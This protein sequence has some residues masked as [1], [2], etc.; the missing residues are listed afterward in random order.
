MEVI[1]CFRKMTLV[2]G[3]STQFLKYGPLWLVNRY[4]RCSHDSNLNTDPTT[5]QVENDYD[6]KVETTIETTFDNDENNTA[7]NNE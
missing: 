1:I 5:Y 7:N 6:T 3:N 4:K 2:T